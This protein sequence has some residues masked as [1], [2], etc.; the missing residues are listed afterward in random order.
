MFHTSVFFRFFVFSWF[1]YTLKIFW[2]F[3]DLFFCFFLCVSP[4]STSRPVLVGAIFWCDF[5]FFAN[6]HFNGESRDYDPFLGFQNHE[7]LEVVGPFLWG[8][9]KLKKKWCLFWGNSVCHWYRAVPSLVCRLFWRKFVVFGVFWVS[10]NGKSCRYAH[11]KKSKFWTQLLCASALISVAFFCVFGL[12]VV[13]FVFLL[14]T[15]KITL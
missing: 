2:S 15:P 14:I 1:V 9:K 8:K 11:F 4:I 12:F 10:R 13:F 6:L 7:D 3:F 5:A